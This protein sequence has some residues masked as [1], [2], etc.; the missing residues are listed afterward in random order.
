MKIDI[1]IG[2]Y[3][4]NWKGKIIPES[5]V[6]P[7]KYSSKLIRRIYEHMIEEGWIH[8]GDLIVDPFGGVALGALDAM[9][10]GLRWRGCELEPRF[11]DLGNQNIGLWNSRYS[12]MP[13]WCTDATLFQGDS[14]NLLAVLDRSVSGDAE[15]SVGSPPYADGSQHTGGDDTHPE[16]M[17]GGVYHGVGLDGAVSSPPYTES[18]VIGGE[19]GNN[20]K[21]Y[22]LNEG[23]TYGATPNQLGAMKATDKGFQI[24]LVRPS[25]P[26]VELGQQEE[27]DDDIQKQETSELGDIEGTLREPK[28]DTGSDRKASRSLNAVDTSLDGSLSNRGAIVHRE[29]QLDVQGR[30]AV[31]GI[32]LSKNKKGSL[33]GVRSTPESLHS[34]QGLGSLQ[35]Q[36]RESSSPMPKLPLESTQE[37]VLGLSKGGKETIQEQRTKSLAQAMKAEGFDGAITSP[38]FQQAKG[39]TP[40]PKPG[41]AIDEALLKRHSAGNSGARGYGET[42]GQ[43][44]NMGDG[45]FDASVSSPPF[46]G[47]ELQ[48]NRKTINDTIKGIGTKSNHAPRPKTSQYFTV[49]YASDVNIGNDSGDDFWMAARQIVEQVYIALRPGAHACWVVKGFVKNKQLVDFPGQWRQL[50]EAVGFESVHE[51]HAMLV[52]HRGTSNTLEG[53]T[54]EHITES[55]SFFRRLAEK[56]GS[57]RIDYETVLCMVKNGD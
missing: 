28:N 10:L 14:R 34:S 12:R 31:R 27:G 25:C 57:P 35:Q 11:A 21:R 3:P 47:S 52:H 54:V 37:N 16:L 22:R 38:P 19:Q 29:G 40:E 6:H 8:P 9:R 32:R 4:S 53:G 20:A 13:H 56:K 46:G 39:G 18:A 1:W 45:D 33:R 36:S 17:E 48:D 42:E 43:L 41:G 15:G 51:H 5:I 24:S 2:C 23:D 26:V 44:A 55:K 30:E 50:C 7:A 49:A